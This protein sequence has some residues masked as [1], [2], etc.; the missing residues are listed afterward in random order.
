MP[1]TRASSR[2][3][4]VVFAH[5]QHARRNPESAYVTATLVPRE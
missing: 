1:T 3:L 2:R 4:V 5:A